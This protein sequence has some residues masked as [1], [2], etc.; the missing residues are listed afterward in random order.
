M[1]ILYIVTAYQRSDDDIITPWMVET[2]RSLKKENVDITVYAPSYKGLGDQVIGGV[3]V[4]RFRYFFKRWEDFTHDSSVPEKIR[5]NSLY[6]LM[7]IPY[8]F[9]GV[10]GLSRVLKAEK[11]DLIHVHWPFPHFIF[12]WW[13][14]K[15][16]RIAG[17]QRI[18]RRG[19][20]LGADQ[21]EKNAAFHALGNKQQ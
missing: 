5:E 8:I 7:T 13:A 10:L 14:K 19:T 12:G 3:T 11:F 21:D 1:K 2:I 16:S 9:F 18:L 15:L 20:S 17:D 4:K 6:L